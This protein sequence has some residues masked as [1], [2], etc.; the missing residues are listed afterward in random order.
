VQQL[1][2]R[3]MSEF[4]DGD[5]MLTAMLKG[6]L[7]DINAHYLLPP[8]SH[9]FVAVEGSREQQEPPADNSDSVIIGCVGLRPLSVGDP[10]YYAEH[11]KSP[12]ACCPSAP[13]DADSTLELS[14]MAVSP[15]ARRRGIGSALLDA[16]IQFCHSVRAS[17]LHLTTMT[18]LGSGPHLYRTRGFTEYG[19]M[20]FNVRHDPVMGSAA[21][22]QA[23]DECGEEGEEQ[24]LRNL[25]EQ[26]M[27]NKERMQQQ[28]QRGIIYCSHFYLSVTDLK[29]Q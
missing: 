19:R 23:F 13:F 24:S 15:T 22:R 20:R 21:M 6:D 10:A 16:C 9:F 27:P 29:Q 1:L 8:R 2:R 4:G 12:S 7:G 17:G 25:S 28:L 3:T 11:C 5:L 26:D 14:R 18:S